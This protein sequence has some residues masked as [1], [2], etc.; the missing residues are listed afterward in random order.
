MLSLNNRQ[1]NVSNGT[2]LVS[3]S[4]GR[5]Q[6][7]SHHSDSKHYLAAFKATHVAGDVSKWLID[8]HFFLFSRACF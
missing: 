7:W 2:L 8:V 3:L 1:L 6:V 5:V 4:D